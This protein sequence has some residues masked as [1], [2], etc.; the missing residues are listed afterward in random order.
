MPPSN[1]TK[2]AL[3][4]QDVKFIRGEITDIKK[5]LETNFV[6]KDEFDPIRNVVYGLVG[7]VLT[8]VFVAVIGLVIIK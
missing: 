3:I 1:N 5:K 8:S 6:T 7:L 2:M 4:A